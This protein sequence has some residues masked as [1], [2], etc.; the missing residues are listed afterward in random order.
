MIYLVHFAD[1]IIVQQ[2]IWW[3]E[4]LKI[5]AGFVLAVLLFI[6]Q[7]WWRA[8][9][10]EEKVKKYCLKEIEHNITVFEKCIET[11]NRLKQEISV[12]KTVVYFDFQPENILYIFTK[13]AHSLGLLFDSLSSQEIARLNTEVFSFFGKQEF[14][15]FVSGRIS[16]YQNK[17]IS[18]ADLTDTFNFVE[19]KAKEA[20]NILKAAR[21][22]I[23]KAK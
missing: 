18:A 1:T 11:T 2:S 3:E 12:G 15:T 20:I 4:T 16:E 17:A 10:K 21:S 19:N 22:G 6:L 7:D 13:N 14:L 23:K 9:R 8:Q 5:L